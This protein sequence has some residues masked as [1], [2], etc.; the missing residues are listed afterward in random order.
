[1]EEI[2]NTYNNEP[3]TL[4]A[5]DGKKIYIP[6]LVNSPEYYEEEAKPDNLNE[7]DW[8]DDVQQLMDLNISYDSRHLQTVLEHCR[9]IHINTTGLELVKNAQGNSPICTVSFNTSNSD[10][11][12]H[13][14]Y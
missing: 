11:L 1:M 9:R 3:R 5:V 7:L 10:I 12:L 14:E 6:A 4:V 2:I 13:T 8:Q